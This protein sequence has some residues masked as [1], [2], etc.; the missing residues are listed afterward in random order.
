MAPKNRRKTRIIDA[1][2]QA[3][4]VFGITVLPLSIVLVAAIS[5]WYLSNRLLDEAQ[6]ANADLPTLGILTMAQFVFVVAT[7]VVATVEA[8]RYSHR[9][10]GPA[11][12]IRRTLM[13]MLAGDLGTRITLRKGD[14]LVEVAAAVNDLMEELRKQGFRPTTGAE[15]VERRDD[16]DETEVLAGT[17][18]TA[19]EHAHGAS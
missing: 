5:L 1:E 10:V 17:T 12:R 14:E 11:L 3:R 18:E 8:L 6:R 9:V 4:M 13:R 15:A 16:P 19:E 7:G 2:S